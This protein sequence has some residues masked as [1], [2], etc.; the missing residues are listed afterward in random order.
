MNT[1][2][3]FKLNLSKSSK[4]EF[5]TTP[6]FY[7]NGEPHLGHAY[8]GIIA[9]IFCR[10]QRLSQT[11][12]GCQLITGTDE[13]GQKIASAAQSNNLPTQDF[14]D[15]LS[16][17]FQVLW[18]KL[19]IEPDAFIRTTDTQHK[20][21]VQR[22]WQQLE[23][24]G[25]IYLGHYSGHY[26]IACE[27]F[28]PEK[29]LLDGASCP[30]HKRE[31][32]FSQEET[33]LFRLENYREALIEYYQSN[34]NCIEPGHYQQSLIEQ[35]KSAPL[36]DLSVSRINNKWGIQVPSNQDHTVYV[37][38][39]A[40]FSYLS[41]IQ[42]CGGNANSL[43]NTQH[44]IGKDILL[45]HSVYWPAFLLALDIKLPQKLIVHGWWTIGGEKISKSN[46]DTTVNPSLF[47][48]KL[49]SDG[50]RYALARHK[51]LYR[52]GNLVLDEFAQTINADLLNNLANLVKRNHTLIT[53]NF[54]G[55]IKLAEISQLDKE[56]LACINKV[57]PVL[58]RIINAYQTRD[59]HRAAKEINSVLA[60]LNGF[61]HQRAPWLVYK[62]QP[63]AKAKQTCL[64]VSNLARELVWVLS[65]IT[66]KLCHDIIEEKGTPSSSIFEHQVLILKD[67]VALCAN[68][69][70]Q[71]V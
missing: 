15:N 9:D 37:W 24:Q 21:N 4:T 8:T 6:I 14:V 55:E 19:A 26:C 71:K 60:E 28:Y 54:A 12:I 58:E 11:N 46:P 17:S 7:A 31:V 40:L 61:F 38:I 30:V 3:S 69:H 41:A 23:Q 70:W 50:L 59:L 25:D 48:D 35:L 2:N 51:P 67:A 43:T 36:D 22:I 64:V 10:Y 65:P 56:S 44:V 57:I 1:N 39:D 16:Q 13:H 66:P 45:F 18:P 62:T 20:L 63:E 42:N 27:Q 34:D 47:S 49:T 33:Y 29:D 52:D 53:K 68:S 32:I 5:I